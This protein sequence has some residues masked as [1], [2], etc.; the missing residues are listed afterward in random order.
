MV[1]VM[2]TAGSLDDEQKMTRE[3]SVEKRVAR[4]RNSRGGGGVGRYKYRSV[5]VPESHGSRKT[6]AAP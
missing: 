4:V 3:G 6:K 2:K 5:L 1:R